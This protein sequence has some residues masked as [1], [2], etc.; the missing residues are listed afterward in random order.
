MYGLAPPKGLQYLLI[1]VASPTRS[2]VIDNQFYGTRGKP[3][4]GFGRQ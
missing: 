1:L 4:D 3:F 2:Q